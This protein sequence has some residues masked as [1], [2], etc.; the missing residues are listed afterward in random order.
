MN[1]TTLAACF[2][3]LEKIAQDAAAPAPVQRKKGPGFK[4]WMKNTAII[5]AGVATG[6]AAGMLTEKALSVLGG[7]KWKGL[8]AGTRRAALTPVIAAAGIGT[9]IAGERMM[10]KR[11][12]ADDE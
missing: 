1:T 5:G 9:M 4:K 7:A 12:E 8:P 10:R 2:D 6:T 11:I 3:E